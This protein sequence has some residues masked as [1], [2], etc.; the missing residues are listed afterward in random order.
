MFMHLATQK[1][2]PFDLLLLCATYLWCCSVAF[3]LTTDSEILIS[4]KNSMNWNLSGWGSSSDHSPCNWSGITCDPQTL[5]VV[6]IDLSDFSIS[7]EFP[8]G[9]CLIRTLLNLSL[10]DNYL[11]GT[12]T[13]RHLSPCSHL[14]V[15]NLSSNLFVGELPDLQHNFAELKVLD[16]SFNNFSGEIP[17]SFGQFSSLKKLH[18][19]ANLLNGSIPSFLCNLSQLSVLQL[20]YNPFKPSPLPES[21]GN[22]SNLEIL[23][24]PYTNLIGEIPESIGKL[25][26]L[27]NFDISNNFVTGKIPDTISQLRS[28]EQIELFNN[29]LYGGLPESLSKLSTLLRFDASQNN[30]TGILPEKI[31]A[32]KLESLN[33]NDNKLTGEIPEVLALNPN[34]VQLK[35]FNN[36]FK[37]KLPANLG[38]YSG[39]V[40]IDVSTN[41]FTGPLPPF[42]CHQNEL[43]QLIAFNN[44]FSG[45][46]PETY[47]ECS[48]LSYVRLGN[49]ELSGPVATNFWGL[50]KLK[51][52]ELSN[53]KL[54]G[55]ILPNIAGA[56]K[57]TQLAISG[58]NF[59]GEL[60]TEI[61]TLQELIKVDV[62][63]NKLSGEL[64]SCI[65][66]LKKLQTV[67]LQENFFSGEIPR[68]VGSLI[69]A[70]DLNFSRNQF[71]G[72]I[73][74]ELTELPVLT[75]LNLAF[76]SLTGEIPAGLTKLQ[77]NVFNVSYNRLYGRVPFGFSKDLYL[78]SLMGNPNLCSPD[79]HGLP[80]C[81]KPKPGAVFIIGVALIAVCFFFLVGASFRVYKTRSMNP[82]RKYNVTVFQPVGFDEKEIFSGLSEENL[83][84]VGGSGQVY[85]VY[86][87]T[88]QNQFVAVKRLLGP[89][90][91]SPET[92]ST[93][94]SE[95]ETLG[96]IRHA[97]IVKLLMCCSGEEFRVLVY[98][99][100]ENGSLGDVLHG[101]K[102]GSLLD[103]PRRFT[104]AVEV[105]QGL[106]YL[107]HD[108]VPAIVH[109]DV[110]SDNILLDSKMRPRVADFGL[111]KVLQKQ[112]GDCDACTMSHLAGSYGYMAPEYAYKSKVTEKSDVYSYGVVLMELITGKRPNDP[113]FGENKDIVKW[114]TEAILTSMDGI[115]C[116]E[117]LHELT[118]AR[119]TYD[120]DQM[121]K[122]L[123]VA[124]L[125]T[126]ELPSNRPSM[127]TVVGMLIKDHKPLS[128]Q[129]YSYH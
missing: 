47:G 81:P 46:L 83:I 22:L 76:N 2:N 77:L 105:A 90:P 9:L 87:K 93:F 15:L 65:S 124:I 35:L 91:P 24:L 110:K 92:K 64:P 70:I 60:P 1:L 119:I 16:L 68:S 71:S 86:L 57:L 43:Q 106:A 6:A 99:Y 66:Q 26:S 82:R 88:G 11:N 98:E 50:S 123:N 109:R 96:Q 126:S 44:R 42:L 30:L 21:I 75:Y 58:N 100:M 122:V 72:E 23:F 56:R 4:V 45:R 33:L 114:I 97:N 55:P 54:Q 3:S 20:G 19:G 85:K 51:L 18:L 59:S 38:R 27:R 41:S 12:L 40:E 7:G 111:A 69:D 84:G 129:R 117:S 95:V 89:E 14:H 80:P 127:R 48:S 67:E 79:L 101:E 103:W 32:M 5:S 61:C 118:D 78:S 128:P 36:S 116:C 25:V 94:K 28:I 107:H 121:E 37:G 74:P 125:C 104:V 49:N 108:C 73:P 112:V 29:Q 113:S 34:L 120:R 13:S 31:A 102:G 8:T 10:S 53:N 63:N 115:K 17:A 62:S 39:L 52:L